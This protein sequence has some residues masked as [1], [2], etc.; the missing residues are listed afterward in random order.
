[1]S[2]VK[3]ESVSIEQGR[4]KSSMQVHSHS[5]SLPEL[6][7]AS[8]ESDDASLCA[9]P[10]CAEADT[11]PP[12]PPPLAPPSKRRMR[13]S[14]WR[15]F[16]ASTSSSMLLRFSPPVPVPLPVRLRFVAGARKGRKTKLYS[17][18]RTAAG[19]RSISSSISSVLW[20]IRN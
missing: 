8:L 12:P 4:V 9:L 19:R 16:S 13:S 1:M 17:F 15:I 3:W 11:L 2:Q 10:A 14:S 5:E 20:N 7:D 18:V 6:S